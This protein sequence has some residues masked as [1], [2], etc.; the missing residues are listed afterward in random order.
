MRFF[1]L[2]VA[3]ALIM[4]PMSGFSEIDGDRTAVNNETIWMNPLSADDTTTVVRVRGIWSALGMQFVCTDIDSTIYIIAEGSN[5]NE[6]WFPLFADTLTV[7]SADKGLSKFLV[8]ETLQ[9]V[10]RVRARTANA[11]T[12]LSLRPL[13]KIGR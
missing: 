6:H 8:Y 10:D 7:T 4:G 5:D 11:D 2:C 9:V 12:S 13:F 3:I 1:L